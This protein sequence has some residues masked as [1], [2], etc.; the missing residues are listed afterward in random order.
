MVLPSFLKVTKDEKEAYNELLLSDR[1]SEETL[2]KEDGADI[3]PTTQKPSVLHRIA[4]IS[5]R[6]VLALLCVWG[7]VS[8]F[9]TIAD[10]IA[11]SR[12]P[13]ERFAPSLSPSCSCGGTTVAEA[14][15]RGCIFTPLAIAWLP[16]HCV[17][18]ELADDFD[19]QG[20]GPHGE[21]DYWSDMNMTRRLTREE[22]G[23]LADVNGVFYATQEWHVTH[24]VY[25]W[26]KHYR[27]RWTGTTIERR[28]NG[29]DHIGHC[30]E[31]LRIRGDLQDIRTVAG[32]AL[33][34]DDPGRS[35]L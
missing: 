31:V 11:Q 21:W 6:S 35:E 19:K 18:T 28:S 7:L 1:E 26:M 10:H 29:L 13:G 4:V 20:P 27:S 30:Q 33:D 14:E 25:T 17:D 32:I 22:V 24:C 12:Q 2:L 15:R 34:A 23:Y 8:I 16:P 5:G 9:N 3:R